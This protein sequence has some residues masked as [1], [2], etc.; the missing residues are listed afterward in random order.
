M[1]FQKG[2]KSYFTVQGDCYRLTIFDKK[3][4]Q[5]MFFI[6]KKNFEQVTEYK[7]YIM[8]YVK[9]KSPELFL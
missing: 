9:R 2:F 4:T 1:F 7:K 8:G 6:P 3:E 5:F